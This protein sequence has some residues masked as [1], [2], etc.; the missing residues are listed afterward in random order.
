MKTKLI[1]FLL[2][3]CFCQ[4]AGAQSA[5]TAIYRHHIGLISSPVLKNI[6]TSNREL[7]VGL[8]YKW[9]HKANGAFRATLLGSHHDYKFT[10]TSSNENK[11]KIMSYLQLTGGYEWQLSVNR[12]WQFYYGAETGAFVRRMTTNDPDRSEY[13]YDPAEATVEVVDQTLGIFMRPFAGIS[14]KLSRRLYLASET[15]VLVQHQRRESNGFISPRN[16]LSGGEEPFNYAN[17]IWR[18]NSIRFQPISNVSL[19]LRF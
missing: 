11:E 15:A 7:P 2:F 12:T 17:G 6:L 5:D 18:D 14:L 16:S 10:S 1:L 4:Y 8:I 9:Q 19:V 13:P 3:F